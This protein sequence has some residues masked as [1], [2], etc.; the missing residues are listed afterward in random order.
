MKANLDQLIKDARD[1]VPDSGEYRRLNR[2]MLKERMAN[3][4]PHRRHHRVLLVS[5]SLVFLMMFS[6][7]LNQ[8]GS[9]DFEMVRED[10]INPR[11]KTIPVMKNEFRGNTF[12][13]PEGFSPEDLDEMS[14]SIMA[15]EGELVWVQGTSY[16]GKTTWLKYVNRTINGKTQGMGGSLEDRP[17][18]EP[19]N[20]LEFL[21]E[22][23]REIV[24]MTKSTPPR[25]ETI[26]TFDGVACNVKIW[27]FQ[28][29]E[30]GEVIRYMATPIQVK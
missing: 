26:M 3:A 21:V 15:D 14:R 11:G 13:V 25:R 6:G 17:H 19:D 9:D 18:V 12:T 23:A 4:G 30:Y 16:G 1:D 20:Y 27:V 10:W 22:H 29:P 24:E 7:Q 5:L 2:V 8:L 28:F